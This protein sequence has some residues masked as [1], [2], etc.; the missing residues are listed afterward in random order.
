MASDWL[1]GHRIRFI[2]KTFLSQQRLVLENSHYQQGTDSII[3]DWEILRVLGL[4]K[5]LEFHSNLTYYFD[6]TQLP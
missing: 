6:S 3:F 2:L 1:K 5:F 4:I